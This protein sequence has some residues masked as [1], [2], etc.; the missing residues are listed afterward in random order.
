MQSF[1][2]WLDTLVEEKGWDV[3]DLIDTRQPGKTE[4]R[5]LPLS[6]VLEHI[7]I[8]PVNEQKVIKGTLVHIDFINGNCLDYFAHLGG[9]LWEHAN[10]FI[11]L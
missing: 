5:A 9:A 3:D 11:N 10:Q 8:A 4:T 2:R 1:S 7:K 6:F